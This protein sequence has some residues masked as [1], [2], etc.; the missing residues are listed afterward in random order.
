MPGNQSDVRPHPDRRHQQPAQPG[1][2]HHQQGH[3]PNRAAHTIAAG[4]LP[5]LWTPPLKRAHF[6]ITGNISWPKPDSS[7]LRKRESAQDM[8]RTQGPE[9]LTP[10]QHLCAA[11]WEHALH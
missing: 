5:T 8:A 6:F 9:T 10:G 11:V 3:V 4:P 7:Q 1:F 2:T